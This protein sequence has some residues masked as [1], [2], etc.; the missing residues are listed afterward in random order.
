MIEISLLA[1]WTRRWNHWSNGYKVF[2]ATTILL[3]LLL[4]YLFVPDESH[5]KYY[6]RNILALTLIVQGMREEIS[7]PV[8]IM[9]VTLLAMVFV[10]FFMPEEIVN[11]YYVK[12]S[13]AAMFIL[14]GISRMPLQQTIR[15]VPAY[16]PGILIVLLC[17]A[18]THLIYHEFF[19]PQYGPHSNPH[20]VAIFVLISL[21]L[22]IYFLYVSKSFQKLVF[23]C[24]LLIELY[25]LLQT[26]SRSAWVAVIFGVLSIV[27]F[28]RPKIRMPVCAAIVLVP[29]CIY[30]FGLSNFDNR[31]N[32]LFV[33]FEE[34]ERLVIWSETFAMQMDSNV[35]S[36]LF[37][38]GLG[39]FSELYQ[40]YSN[41][42]FAANIH[43]PHNALLEILFSSG[44]FGVLTV[45][46]GY[47]LFCKFLISRYRNSD[48]TFQKRMAI[49]IMNLTVMLSIHIFLTYPVLAE[50]S[51]LIFAMIVG[52][53][54]KIL[55]RP[56][57]LTAELSG[58][59]SAA[60]S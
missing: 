21:P 2:I 6:V 50:S 23:A 38:H 60:R 10:N 13:F 3:V 1:H 5:T 15:G 48:N 46:I 19:E 56:K 30:G 26:Q 45:T 57:R 54:V 18:A 28:V 35:W 37:G 9:I 41:Y 36:W 31:V 53:S 22:T 24:L 17:A 55:Q 59:H 8:I 49:L 20:V 7:K 32:D 11:K 25:L 42:E 33:N 43:F 51:I 40:Q 39:S 4:Y 12:N 47:L 52:I 44:L 16:A 14:L 34:E 58:L 29:T 27:P